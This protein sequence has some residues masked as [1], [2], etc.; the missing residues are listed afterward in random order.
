MHFH[1]Q[2][3]GAHGNGRA[4]Q[5]RNF[6]SFPRPMTGIHKNRQMTQPLHCRNQAQ[7]E[8]VPRVVGKC[9]YAALAQRHIVVALAQNIFCRHQEFFQRR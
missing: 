3:I 4:R 7:I 5:W 6:I 8:S 1:H 9:S 2:S